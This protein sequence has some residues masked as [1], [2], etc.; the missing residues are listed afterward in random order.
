MNAQRLRELIDL[1]L[2][3]E[4][5]LHTQKALQNL[6]AAL[7]NLVNQP[8][9][10]ST[11]TEVAQRLE[12][13]RGKMAEL[14]SRFSPQEMQ[15][16]GELG[17]LEFFG[18]TL[19]ETITKEFSENGLTPAVAHK[20]VSDLAS[21]RQSYIDSIRVLSQGLQAVGI[22]P[23][24][25]APD[26]AELGVLLPRTLFHNNLEELAK[27]LTILNRILRAF[28]ELVT[29]SVAPIEVKEISTSDPI[30]FLGLDPLIAAQVAVAIR[31]AL[32]TWRKVEEI[33]KLRSETA[34][35]SAFTQKEVEDFFDSKIKTSVDNAV[36]QALKD[37]LGSVDGKIGRPQEQR[38]DLEW[39][40]RSILA[41]VERG[42][43]IEPRFL[44]PPAGAEGDQK[45][46]GDKKRE[47]AFKTL[48]E[49]GQELEYPKPDPAPVLPLPPAS[50]PKKGEPG[51]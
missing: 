23:N 48:E 6:V 50:P 33:R 1:L 40:L 13:L 49:I 3:D 46:E 8:Q 43:T 26:T 10:A 4:D 35:N 12:D 42:M 36:Q 16:L 17:A 51:K 9:Q 25:V 7:A 21:R 24:I 30:F 44:E 5:E 14:V 31:W 11:Q 18:P 32:G 22:A 47:E 2:S 41:R 29:G 28:S 19:T 15:R 37:F 38:T 45:S 34:K 39:A 20:R 27:E